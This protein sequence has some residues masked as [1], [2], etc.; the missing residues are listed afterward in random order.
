MVFI[1]VPLVGTDPRLRGAEEQADAAFGQGAALRRHPARCA[2]LPDGRADHGR[3]PPEDRR[4]SAMWSRNASFRMQT[5]STLYE[6]PLLLERE[7]LATV[8]CRK[9]GHCRQRC[10]GPCGVERRWSSRVKARAPAGVHCAWSVNIPQLHD[11]YLQ[12]C[13]SRCSTAGTENDAVVAIRMG[14]LRAAGRRRICGRSCWQAAM[15]ILRPWRLRRPGRGRH[16]PRRPG[17]RRAEP[18]AVS[19]HLPRVCRSAVIEFARHVLGWADAH[20]RRNLTRRAPI[21][22]SHLMPDQVGV[23]AKGGTM[24]L[25]QYPCMTG[26]RAATRPRRCTA[27]EEIAERHRHR[28][29]FN[30]AY[31]AGT[32]PRQGIAARR[33]LAGRQPGGDGGE[34]PALAVVY[35]GG[36]VPSGI[37]EPTQPTPIRCSPAWSPPRWLKRAT[38]LCA[39]G[40]RQR[41]TD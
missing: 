14:G 28:Y 31:R 38:E 8:V 5:A 17:M 41:D 18:G 7:G 11:A 3:D 2:G 30:N 37:Q 20:S 36:P 16:G 9:L 23:T 12:R 21:R 19:G 32:L 22:S 1:H 39:R 29:E 24:R 10:T 15:R 40:E 33:R 13:G 27:P 6:V 34:L 25:G 26:R 4:C 35:V